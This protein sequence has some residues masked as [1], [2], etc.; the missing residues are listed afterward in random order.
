MKPASPLTDPALR[1][2]CTRFLSGHGPADAAGWVRKLAESP[3]LGLGLDVYSEGPAFTLLEERVAGL[4][5]KPAAL[6]FHKGVTAQQ[7]ALLAH[8]GSTGRRVV[9]VHPKSHLAQDEMDALD[10]L[11]GL[12]PHRLGGD[13]APFT[14]ADLERS[15]ETFGVVTVEL[16][17]RR[18]GFLAPSWEDLVAI[19]DWCR[20]Q[21]V[22]FHLDGARLWEIAPHYGRTLAEISDLADSVYVS[23]YKG[24]GGMGGCVLA[25]TPALI[26]AA[27]PWRNRFGGDLPCIFPYVITALDGLDR[28]LPRMPAYHA[29][30]LAIA[31][32]IAGVPGLTVLPQPPAGNSFQVHFDIGRD[33]LAERAAAVAR[34]DKT[35]L[36]SRVLPTALPDR[37]ISEIVVGAAT[38]DWTPSE[39]ALALGELLG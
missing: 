3:H 29:H 32:A 35:W 14:A 16:P 23:F 8:I 12:Y 2:S 10:R 7:A 28:H 36:L 19:S 20:A 6:F 1:A 26:A 30:A 37:A 11:A 31:E 17:L 18:A 13:H 15:A 9:A 33:A 34:T 4:L 39:A 5:G 21:A 38:L 27:R 22:P 24:L 25:G